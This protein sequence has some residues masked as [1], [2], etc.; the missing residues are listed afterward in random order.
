MLNVLDFEVKFRSD[1][2]QAGK[3]RYIALSNILAVNNI[4]LADFP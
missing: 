3:A 1:L 4:S 2:A